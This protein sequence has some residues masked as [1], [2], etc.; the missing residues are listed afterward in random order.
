MPPH[1]PSWEVP[2]CGRTSPLGSPDPRRRGTAWVSALG[3]VA[4]QS[5]PGPAGGF[6]GPGQPL[7][8]LPRPGQPPRPCEA[9]W[10]PVPPFKGRSDRL[11]LREAAEAALGSRRAGDLFPGLGY[12]PAEIEPTGGALPVSHHAGAPVDRAAS[13]D[14]AHALEQVP[15]WTRGE[16][17]AA[18]SPLGGGLSGSDR[19]ASRRKQPR[20]GEGGPGACQ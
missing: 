8:R 19:P 10:S 16:P 12:G 14:H 15:P 20:A 9:V 3:T 7:R 17:K 1:G 2:L 4:G 18:R 5:A 6:P 13:L 11:H